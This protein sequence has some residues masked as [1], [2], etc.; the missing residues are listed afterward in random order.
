MQYPT[1]FLVIDFQSQ[2]SQLQSIRHFQIIPHDLDKFIARDIYNRC[3]VGRYIYMLVLWNNLSI[4]LS[5]FIYV[6][7]YCCHSVMSDSWQPHGLQHTRLPSLPPS[8]GACTNSC[9]LSQW[10]IIYIFRVNQSTFMFSDEYNNDMK[11][12]YR[13]KHG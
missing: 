9:S 4:K 1:N 7:T 5:N 13:R 6:V 2:S 3:L 12:T 8:P 10:H 11:T